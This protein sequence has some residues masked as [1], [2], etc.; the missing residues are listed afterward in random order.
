MKEKCKII[1]LKSLKKKQY[2]TL[3]LGAEYAA[4]LGTL[5]TR[6]VMMLYGQS[7]SGKSVFALQLAA[8]LAREGK[9]LYNSH[10]EKDNKTLQDRVNMFGVDAARL[11]IGVSLDFDQMVEKIRRNHY[12]FV[13]IDSVQYMSFTYDQLIRLNELFRRKKKFGVIM[14]SF[15]SSPGNP[16]R[17][18]DLLHASDVKCRFH[19]G[20]LTVVSRYLEYPVGKILFRTGSKQQLTLW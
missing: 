17:A 4:L 18:R 19:D 20:R 15:G 2:E 6:F 10:E 3:D 14:V 11:Y 9:V 13:V 8:R 12:H 5:Q 1:S 16:D 7:G